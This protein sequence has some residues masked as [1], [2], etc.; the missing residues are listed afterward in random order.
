MSKFPNK[1]FQ[2]KCPYIMNTYR[3]IFFPVL[4]SFLSYEPAKIR[5]NNM[6]HLVYRHPKKPLVTF[7]SQLTFVYSALVCE[8]LSYLTSSYLA[9]TANLK[10]TETSKKTKDDMGV[11]SED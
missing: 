8:L 11:W 10:N 7:D 4:I 1:R 6:D 5:Q 3:P 9:T 2:V